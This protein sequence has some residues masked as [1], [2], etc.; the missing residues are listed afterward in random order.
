M[1]QLLELEKGMKVLEIGTGSG[2]QAAVLAAMRVKTY[3]MEIRPN[4]A[5]EV[6]ILLKKL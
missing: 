2:Y 3:S 5:S 1:S 6:K 4:L